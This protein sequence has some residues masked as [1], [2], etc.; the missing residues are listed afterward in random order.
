MF[1]EKKDVNLECA[2]YVSSEKKE[3]ESKGFNTFP[4]LVLSTQGVDG[5]TGE[6]IFV[7]SSILPIWSY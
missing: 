5:S 6:R 4:W 2:K 7:N 3:Q 1:S